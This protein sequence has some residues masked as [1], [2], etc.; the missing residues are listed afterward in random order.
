[1]SRHIYSGWSL[2]TEGNPADRQLSEV[3]LDRA[4]S[5]LALTRAAMDRLVAVASSTPEMIDLYVVDDRQ[6]GGIHHPSSGPLPPNIRLCV[7]PPSDS[8][9]R[10][11]RR[12]IEDRYRQS[13]GVR[14]WQSDPA[15]PFVLSTAT[16]VHRFHQG[17]APFTLDAAG[18]GW[19]VAGAGDIHTGRSVIR[20]PRHDATIAELFAIQSALKMAIK[21]LPTL[22]SAKEKAVL[23][24]GSM[25]A[26]EALAYPWGGSKHRRM[27]AGKVIELLNRVKCGDKMDQYAVSF[28]LLDDGNAPY[29]VAAKELACIAADAYR[30]VSE[31]KAS[32]KKAELMIN[33]S[34]EVRVRDN[35][36]DAI[37]GMPYKRQDEKTETSNVLPLF[38]FPDH[39]RKKGTLL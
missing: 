28:R 18:V 29:S 4:L 19:V 12:V 3:T 9:T 20:V 22:R 38:H 39:H 34:R 26:L 14:E 6:R 16:E 2:F 7:D 23:C 17:S 37:N 25:E 15:I 21:H 1:M 13:V 24:T 30:I 27:A 11:A 5:H 35:L 32:R 10:R 33:D 31:G 8:L 36:V